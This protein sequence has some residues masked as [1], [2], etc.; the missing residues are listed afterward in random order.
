MEDARSTNAGPD[1]GESRPPFAGR[2][3]SCPTVEG[4]DILEELGRG[5]SSVVYKARDRSLGRIVALKMMAAGAHAPPDQ[6]ARIA[7]EARAVASLHHPN[8]VQ[9]HEIGESQGVPF[10]S[11]EY[12]EGESLDRRIDGRPQPPQAAARLV[13][14]LARAIH[15]A[16]LR[17]IV[18]RDVKP[19]NILIEPD[20]TPKLT[21]FGLAKDL[22][23]RSSQTRSG[24]LL[25]TP[26]YMAPEQARGDV[27]D[28]GP[29]ADIHALGAILYEMLVGRPPFLGAS[30]YET[31][32]QVVNDEPVRPSRLVPRLPPDIE[33][34]CLECLH[35][36]PQRRYRDAGALAEDCRRF[37]AGEPILSRPVSPLQRGW[38][39]C[40]RNPRF[41]ALMASTLLLLVFVAVGST[42]T[43]LLVDGWRR[44]AESARKAAED[45]RG[46]AEDRKVAAERAGAEA[47]VQRIAAEEARSRALELARVAD[48]QAGL[49][50]STIQILVDKV[51]TRLD[52]TPGTHGLKTDLLET[53]LAGLDTI[54]GQMQGLDTTETTAL[55]AHM[56]LGEIYRQLGSSE[57]AMQE[58]LLSEGIARKRVAV[59]PDNMAGRGNLATVLSVVSDM[60]RELRRDVRSSIAALEESL[61]IWRGMTADTAG[62]GSV[63]AATIDRNLAE[64]CTRLA[65]IRFRLGSPSAARPLFEEAIT[66]RRALAA[67]SPREPELLRDLAR[68][69]SAMAEMAFVVGDVD[70]A[71]ERYAECI[72]TAETVATLAPDDPRSRA[73][74]A[75]ALG[76]QGDLCLRA[77]DPGAAR[78]PFERALA[79]N[80]DLLAEDPENIDLMRS[81]GVDLYRLA[82]LA[83]IEGLAE[84]KALVDECVALRRRIVALDPANSSHAAE[85]MLAL[86]RS[87]DHRA[88][89]AM[90]EGM[91]A[92]AA[93]AEALVGVASCYAQCSRAAADDPALADRYA[94]LALVALE[95]AIERGYDDPVSIRTSPDLAPLR[96]RDSF[97]ALIATIAEP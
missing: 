67:A 78:P 33:T 3:G 44:D 30:P 54:A 26:S 6:L 32:M 59:R 39:W 35:K 34:I 88:A 63:S 48:E 51:Q 18:H 1:D 86:A 77:G 38:R 91:L 55:A 17:G 58:Y 47:D 36:E 24:T 61:S 11:L 49:A 84:G 81:V 72:A 65:V 40:R 80:R 46:L 13:G 97:E 52:D 42:L 85:L 74:L 4:Y 87:G 8:I 5:S 68:S 41:A 7:I 37:L 56:R 57:K 89:A 79:I 31:T 92:S 25:G 29:A 75:N 73:E 71:R 62:E 23:S 93:D 64:A 28:V 83:D 76:N 27:D 2:S 21:D 43:A 15:A 16:H 70:L 66:L 90:A 10:L 50:L 60:H 94:G 9:I 19:A 96:R 20:G 45:A 12:V 95:S 22:E 82:T 53:A 14:T 69:C